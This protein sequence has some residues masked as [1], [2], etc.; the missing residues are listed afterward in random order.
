M[1]CVFFTLHLFLAEEVNTSIN[2]GAE[3]LDKTKQDLNQL[4]EEATTLAG[5]AKQAGGTALDHAKGAATAA[6]A[7]GS[8]AAE[9]IVD[10]KLKESENVIN[11]SKFYQL[12]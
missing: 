4:A 5:K 1:F 3:A 12:P 8:K 2:N 11:L 6:I 7:A 10:Q 9:E